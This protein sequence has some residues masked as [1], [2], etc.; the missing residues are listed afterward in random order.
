MRK[1]FVQFAALLLAFCLIPIIPVCAAGED[2]I[3]R[4]GLY[5]GNS[6]LDGAN[7]KNSVGSGYRFGYYDSDNQFIELAYTAEESISVVK[8]TNVYY[9]SYNDY[10]SYHEDLTTSRVAVGCYHLQLPDSY[11][12][13]DDASEAAEYYDGGFVAYI[14]DMFYVRVGNYL[15]KSEAERA[16]MELRENTTIEGTSAYGVSVVITGTDTIVFQYDDL[17]GGTG[18][19]IEPNLTDDG[20]K[21]ITWFKG[22]QWYGGFRYE[23]INGGDLTVVNLVPMEDYINCVI[24]REMGNSFPLEALKAQAVAARSYA[25]TNF[26]RHTASHFD[27][28]NTTHCQV[29]Y[30]MNTTG[31]NTIRAVEETWGE[32]A[33][34]DGEICQTFYHSCDGGATENSENVWTSELPYLRGVVDPYEA[35]IENRIPGYSWTKTYTGKELQNLM[36]NNGHYTSC[37]EVVDVQVAKTTP[38]GNVYSVTVTDVNGKKFTVSKDSVRTVFGVSSLRYTISGGSGNA[39]AGSSGLDSVLGAWAIDGNGNLTQIEGGPVYAITGDGVQKVTAS[40]ASSDGTFVFSGTGKGHNLG[41]SQWGAYAMA[42]E[43]YTYQ[44]ILKFYFTGVEIYE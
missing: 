18:L 17:G 34:Y 1:K 40:T 9:G 2:T 6:A 4:V 38:T 20:E 29:Y 26:G 15:T 41:M 35:L 22:Y 28:C 3:I 12:H 37:G 10:T 23:R 24:S 19:G 13:Y 33:W 5:Y 8:T 30:G 36:I 27:I 39:A 43:G 16:Q 32:Y 14:G 25:V 44:E 31:E 11:R 7:L 21:Y 42:E